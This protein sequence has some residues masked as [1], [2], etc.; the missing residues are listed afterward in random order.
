LVLAGEIAPDVYGELRLR[1]A[2]ASPGNLKEGTMRKGL[3]AVGT[4][5]ILCAAISAALWAQDQKS[6]DQAERVKAVNLVRLINTVEVTYASGHDNHFATWQELWDSGALQSVQ[7]RWKMVSGLTLSG[8][9]EVI[10]GHH[11]DIL[12]SPDGKSFSIALH[13]TRHGDGLFS[14]FSDQSG[15]IY[16]GA[17]IQ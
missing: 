14:V 11:L 2:P 6:P 1:V 15:I 8:G 13:D 5:L 7:A 16:L 10:P 3:H 9:P 12:V 4:V 17:P